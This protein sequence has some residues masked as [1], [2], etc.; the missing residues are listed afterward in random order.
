M[1]ARLPHKLTVLLHDSRCVTELKLLE[2]VESIS[3]FLHALDPVHFFFFWP[4]TDVALVQF[5]FLLST[6]SVDNLSLNFLRQES[7]NVLVNDPDF[8]RGRVRND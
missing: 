2:N 1:L 5:L 6:Q 4:L 3:H 7:K 8:D